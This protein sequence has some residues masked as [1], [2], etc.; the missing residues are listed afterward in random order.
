MRLFFNTLE[1]FKITQIEIKEGS[2]VKKDDVEI[3]GYEKTEKPEQ[4]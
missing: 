4:K 2:K 3:V 1:K